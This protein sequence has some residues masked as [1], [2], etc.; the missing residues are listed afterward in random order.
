[1]PKLTKRSWEKRIFTVDMEPA[2]AGVDISSMDSSAP[3]TVTAQDGTTLTVS[4]IDY[5]TKKVAFLV[6]GGVENEEYTV[7]V[8]VNTNG[9]PSQRL[10]AVVPLL[11]RGD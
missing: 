5:T 2:L 7:R 11:V 9:S 6:A 3:V 4:D 8:R 1:M 10:E